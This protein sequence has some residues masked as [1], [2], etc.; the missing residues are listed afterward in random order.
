M[1][2][3]IEQKSVQISGMVQELN[4]LKQKIAENKRHILLDVSSMMGSREDF[5]DKMIISP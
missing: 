5:N 1:R 4:L 2:S 3:Q